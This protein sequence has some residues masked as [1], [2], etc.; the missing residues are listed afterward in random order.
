MLAIVA[1]AHQLIPVV[2]GARTLPAWVALVLAAPIALGFGL[3]VASFNGADIFAPAAV[4]LAIGIGLWSIVMLARL[5]LGPR[6]VRLRIVLA[7]AVLALGSALAI[8]A[9]MAL[10]FDGVAAGGW[11]RLAPVHALLALGGF[12]STVIVAVS[13]RLVPM[14]ALSH[15]SNSSARF[16]PALV[17]APLFALAACGWLAWLW[18]LRIALV[19]VLLVFVTFIA[20][21]AHT[22]HHRI[23]RQLDVS[24]RYAIVSWWFAMLAVVATLMATFA[25]PFAAVAVILAVL[26]WITPSILGYAYKIVGFLAWQH[27]RDCFPGAQLPPL[28]GAVDLRLAGLALAALLTGTLGS[29]VAALGPTLL[30][31][32]EALYFAGVI[33]ALFVLARIVTRYWRSSWNKE[34]ST[35]ADSIH[36]NRWSAS[37]PNS[38]T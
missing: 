13:Y 6:E 9:G 16:L 2:T 29:A 34:S 15:T 7:L 30:D 3:L 32:P 17:L 14:F 21:Q 18:L 20:I 8:G 27:A 35:A 12:A 22:V 23:R 25:P 1:A 10:A 38:R 37:L 33:G 26:G 4:A 24:L 11:L 19:A 36:P 28:S 5:L 31:I